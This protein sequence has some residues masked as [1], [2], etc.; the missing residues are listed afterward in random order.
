MLLRRM[1]PVLAAGVVGLSYQGQS[2]HCGEAWRQGRSSSAKKGGVAPSAETMRSLVHDLQDSLSV[3]QVDTT[4]EECEQRGKPWNSYHASSNYPGV[5]VQPENTEQVS[6]IMK[7]CTRYSVPVVPF[8]G[9]TSLEGQLLAPS[10]GVSLDF[11]RMKRVIAVRESDLD[12]TVEAGLGYIELNEQLRPLG[13]WFPLDPGP[14]ASVGGMIATRC[15]GSTAVRY[16]SMRENVL[17]MTAVLPDGTVLTTGGRARKSSAGYDL[18]RLFVGSEGTLAVATEVTLKLHPLPAHSHAVRVAFPSVEAAAKCASDTLRAGLTVGRCELID[19]VMVK[20]INSANPSTQWPEEVTLLYELTGPSR[21]SVEEQ[22]AALRGLAATSGATGLTVCD[23]PAAAAQLWKYRKE[24]LWS[25]MSQHPDKDPMITD[26]CVP[27]SRLSE[28]ISTTRKDLDA[29]PLHCP[30]IAHAGDGNFHVL[31]MFDP[32]LPEER[33]EA[34]RLADLM[35]RRAI[36]MGGTCTGEHGVGVGKRHLLKEELGAGSM[37]LMRDI[38]A[39][40]D[41][42]GIMNPGKVLPDEE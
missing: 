37:Q 31:I 14:G 39:A 12:C 5:I 11:S 6:I 18:A 8:G 24:C 40:V 38:K 21:R 4:K 7:L 22:T 25:T 27:L 26:V 41:P 23:E 30:I 32:K 42:K 34:Q 10:G 19:D 29:S 28:L 9:G 17:N 20:D 3:D 13:L 36:S 33:V 15:S 2:S 35:A 16:G 1:L